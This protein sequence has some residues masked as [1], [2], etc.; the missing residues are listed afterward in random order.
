MIVFVHPCFL[1]C[2]LCT[3]FSIH[4]LLLTSLL[5]GASNGD[6]TSVDI[7]PVTSIASHQW[8]KPQILEPDCRDL[9]PGSS[10]FSPTLK[11]AYTFLS[12]INITNKM[13]FLLP[14]KLVSSHP[15]VTLLSRVACMF[16]AFG[17]S[18]FTLSTC[19]RLTFGPHAT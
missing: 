7:S 4:F 11:Y 9:N 1:L 16:W 6:R 18:I 2:V 12:F 5:K 17:L 19:C 8:L 13:C 15:L 3:C 10:C 14:P